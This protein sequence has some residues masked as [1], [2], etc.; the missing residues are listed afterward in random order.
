MKIQFQ[1]NSFFFYLFFN[2][3]FTMKTNLYHHGNLLILLFNFFFKEANNIRD[4]KLKGPNE[5]NR[6]EKNNSYFLK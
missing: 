4:V 3:I 2:I 6:I 1:K 5:M